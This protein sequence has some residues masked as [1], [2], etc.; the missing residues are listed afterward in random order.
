ML[1]GPHVNLLENHLTLPS[2]HRQF[3]VGPSC[4]PCAAAHPRFFSF[5]RRDPCYNFPPGQP[6]VDSC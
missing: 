1:A 5:G 6:A 3:F 2:L 4:Q